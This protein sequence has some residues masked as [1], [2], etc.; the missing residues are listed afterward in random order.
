LQS[1]RPSFASSLTP[2]LA[3]SLTLFLLL[4]LSQL[5][6]LSLFESN[7]Q[8][9]AEKE[10]EEELKVSID[11]RK[12]GK[13]ERVEESQEVLDSRAYKRLILSS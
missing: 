7:P 5:A 10:E 13:K 1:Q 3:L 9:S 12:E 11:R 2:L 8:I 6:L 4:S